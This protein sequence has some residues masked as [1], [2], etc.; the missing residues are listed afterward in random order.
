MSE[1]GPMN[2]APMP[3]ESGE[4]PQKPRPPRD[5]QISFWIW[6]LSAAITFVAGAQFA[7]DKD[8]FLAEFLKSGSANGLSREDLLRVADATF[9]G[10]IIGIFAFGLLYVLFVFKMRGGRNW[11]R[12][13]LAALAVLGLLS[14]AMT[15]GTS[16]LLGLVSVLVS[17]V[18]LVMM[19][20]PAANA[21]FNQFKRTR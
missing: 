2:I 20:T 13:V 6:L 12:I 7:S 5:V 19:F 3:A 9:V 15:I 21:F 17:I 10:M 11:A 18:G 8:A 14:Q 1:N 16:D 4:P